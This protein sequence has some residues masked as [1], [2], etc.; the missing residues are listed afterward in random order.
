MHPFKLFCV[1][2]FNTKS[3]EEIMEIIGIL[4]IVLIVIGLFKILGLFFHVGIWMI[5][6]PFKILGLVIAS[7]VLVAVLIPLGILGALASIIVAPLA[8]LIPLLPFLLVGAGIW[9]I[10]RH[11]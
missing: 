5:A 2:L 7:V 6:L 11:N 4:L 9:L 1:S 8:L 10:L 3:S